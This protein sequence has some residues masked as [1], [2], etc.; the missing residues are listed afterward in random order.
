MPAADQQVLQ[1]RVDLLRPRR[2]LEILHQGGLV[3]VGAATRTRR[4]PTRHGHRVDAQELGEL[5]LVQ[6]QRAAQ[7]PDLFA[8]HTD[9]LAQVLARA[10]SHAVYRQLGSSR[11]PYVQGPASRR[12]LLPA[13]PFRPGRAA[14]SLPVRAVVAQLS[15]CSHGNPFGG[16][17]PPQDALEVLEPLVSPIQSRVRAARWRPPRNAAQR[18]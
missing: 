9:S 6:A 5:G 17:A 16:V 10:K 18:R 13:G 11:Q 12:S 14:H 15:R 7:P 1:R 8:F 4:L 2:L 3:G